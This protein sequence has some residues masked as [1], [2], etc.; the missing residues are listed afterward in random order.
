MTKPTFFV[1]EDKILASLFDEG[2]EN[3]HLYKPGA[4]PMYSE[5]LL[6]LLPEDYY[7]KI[8]VHE[9][10]YLKDEYRLK[11][12]HIDDDTTEIPDRY[13]GRISRTCRVLEELRE[14]KKQYDYVFLRNVDNCLTETGE[15]ST[16][17]H[18][19]LCEA[20]RRGLIDRRVYA[21]GGMSLDNIRAAKDLGFGGVVICGDLWNRFDIHNE[22]DYK[23]L[24]T[25]FE[26]LRK[27]IG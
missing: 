3:L 13:K 20:S 12:I 25:H 24:I 1:E 16:F 9:H 26:R 17:T 4:S 22:L 6:T 8:T 19:Q 23:E 2:L 11:G 10:F 15:A 14:A 27:A 5:R 18:E 21:L 7:D